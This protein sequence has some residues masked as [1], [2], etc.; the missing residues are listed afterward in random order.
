M[1]ISQMVD[2]KCFKFCFKQTQIEK[3]KALL[4]Q[5]NLT[6]ML[7]VTFINKQNP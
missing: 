2:L 7:E 1:H 5:G 3:S 4:Q 6:E